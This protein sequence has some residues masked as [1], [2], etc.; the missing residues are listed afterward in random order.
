MELPNRSWIYRRT[1]PKVIGVTSEFIH[2]VNCFIRWCLE[3]K[4]GCENEMR[5]PCAKCKNMKHQTVPVL[6]QHIFKWDF[7]PKYYNWI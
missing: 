1:R 6:K 2:G 3:T 4:Y 5:C 7:V